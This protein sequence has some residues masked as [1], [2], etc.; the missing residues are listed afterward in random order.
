MND[1]K[2]TIEIG[3]ICLVGAEKSKNA[4]VERLALF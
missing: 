1:V 3:A 4:N 2:Y